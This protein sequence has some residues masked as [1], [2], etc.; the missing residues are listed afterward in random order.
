MALTYSAFAEEGQRPEISQ[1]RLKR[2]ISV[3]LGIRPDGPMPVSAK[4]GANRG[5]WR[6]SPSHMAQ[7]YP[8]LANSEALRGK[9]CGYRA[10]ASIARTR[11]IQ[12][13]LRL[14]AAKYYK[15]FIKRELPEPHSS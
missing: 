6:L 15:E 11:P 2:G 7:N 9:P 14:S 5:S 8:G 12:P 1:P 4:I 10:P 13:G 3:S